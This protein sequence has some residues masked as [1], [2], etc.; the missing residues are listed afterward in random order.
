MAAG[1]ES[2]PA[3]EPTSSR[4]RAGAQ[5]RKASNLSSSG[6]S[7]TPSKRIT[8]EKASLGHPPI[9]NGP[10]TRARQG[11]SHLASASAAFAV[12]ASGAGSKPAEKA[13]LLGGLA[14]EAAA[15]GAEQ[16]SKES[17]LEALEAGL[18]AKFEAIRSR[19]ASAHVV[20]S[21]CGEF[22]F[23]FCLLFGFGLW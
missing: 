10:L 7:S 12:A 14:G 17:E 19:S 11:P 18:E 21:H 20:P 5:K 4:R 2:S 13:K 15:A 9:H 1:G 3:A 16:L 22:Q 8:R 6:S 23:L